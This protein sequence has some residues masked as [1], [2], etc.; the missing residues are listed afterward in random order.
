ML[1]LFLNKINL[2]PATLAALIQAFA[3]FS[4]LSLVWVVKQTS[5]LFSASPLLIWTLVLVHAVLAVWLAYLANMEKWWRWIHFI[6]PIAVWFMLQWH[7]PDIVY[8]I[9]FLISLGL[10]WTTFR[11]QVPFFPSSLAVHQQVLTLIPEAE[12]LH[13]IDIGS[14][15]G[16]LSMFIANKRPACT[17]DGIEIAPLPWLISLIRA[18]IKRSKAIFSMGD[19]RLLDFARYDLIFA[20]LSPAAMP[21]L[22]QKARAQMRPGCLLVSYE[23]GVDGVEPMRCIKQNDDEKM[24]YVWKM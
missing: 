11:T 4:V 24:L 23:F 21:A 17:V 9:G 15:L 13:I 7:I 12:P 20:Y 8:L 6:F 10:Y 3:F 5:L 14:G 1:Q 19:Y 16:D 18:K 2:K 22:W